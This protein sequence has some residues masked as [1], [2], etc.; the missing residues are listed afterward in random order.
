VLRGEGLSG[1]LIDTDP[2]VTGKKP[3]EPKLK[4]K[5]FDKTTDIVK[6]L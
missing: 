5:G 1:E 4:S 3:L 6:N 2:Q